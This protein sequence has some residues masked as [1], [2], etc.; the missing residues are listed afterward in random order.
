MNTKKR[1]DSQEVRNTEGDYSGHQSINL[2]LGNDKCI[3]SNISMKNSIIQDLNH[4]PEKFECKTVNFQNNFYSWN[5]GTIN[6]RS[7]KEKVKAQ[8]CI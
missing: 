5:F 1:S 2:L 8:K 6:I 4:Q 7:G 3:N